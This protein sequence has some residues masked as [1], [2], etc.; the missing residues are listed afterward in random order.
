MCC[1]SR[2]SS[3]RSRD[4]KCFGHREQHP[5]D[6]LSHCHIGISTS[7]DLRRRQRWGI[8]YYRRGGSWR[9]W[10][11]P[12]HRLL[13]RVTHRNRLGGRCRGTSDAGPERHPICRARGDYG[14]GRVVGAEFIA[15]EENQATGNRLR[16]A[17]KQRGTDCG[18]LTT[19]LV[20]GHTC[21]RGSRYHSRNGVRS[22]DDSRVRLSRNHTP[23]IYPTNCQHIIAAPCRHLISGPLNQRQ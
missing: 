14:R 23:P 11:H 1:P 9:R 13:E 12:L 4:S 8:R 19:R 20:D 17:R 10:R 2:R 5:G 18:D 7:S 3:S 21:R 22:L 16:R 6:K 15:E